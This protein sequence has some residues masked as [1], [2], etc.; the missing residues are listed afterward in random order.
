MIA[1]FKNA[2]AKSFDQDLI[3]CL[4]ELILMELTLKKTSI[5]I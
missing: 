4:R 2:E 1:H 5:E 3:L